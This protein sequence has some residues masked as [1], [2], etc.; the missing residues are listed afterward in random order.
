MPY[1]GYSSVLSTLL[2]NGTSAVWGETLN[3][4]RKIHESPSQNV[5]QVSKSVFDVLQGMY[6]FEQVA[7]VPMKGKDKLAVWELTPLDGLVTTP[8]TEEEE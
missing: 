4:A 8:D 2:S 7:D 3:I 6:H 5:I 1:N